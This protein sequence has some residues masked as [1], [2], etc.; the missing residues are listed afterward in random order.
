MVKKTFK[1]GNRIKGN[2]SIKKLRKNK[3]KTKGGSGPGFVN[4]SKKSNNSKKSNKDIGDMDFRYVH[5]D[6]EHDFAIRQK[7]WNEILKSGIKDNRAANILLNKRIEELEE[8]E[9]INQMMSDD[10]EYTKEQK[11][12]DKDMKNKQESG[13]IPI[14]PRSKQPTYPLPLR[15]VQ[16]PTYPL[17]LRSVQ[18]PR[19]NYYNIP[20]PEKFDNIF[21]PTSKPISQDISS[22][23][24][25]ESDN[26]QEFNF[27]LVFGTNNSPTQN[28][29][30][31][32]RKKRNTRNT[33][34][35]KKSDEKKSNDIKP[36]AP[37]EKSKMESLIEE[38]ESRNR[39]IFNF[40][41][42]QSKN[43]GPKINLKE[44]QGSLFEEKQKSKP[45]SNKSKQ[46]SNKPKSKKS[47]SN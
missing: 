45:K 26:S 37:K 24:S 34:K 17:P 9:K 25:Q 23:D 4:P 22:P 8:K 28:P 33:R 1:A 35:N 32:E 2:R 19:T 36:G 15:S 41:L 18:Q 39:S 29:P 44:L 16:Q 43:E 11:K 30:S 46:K 21:E 12:I 13:L 42:I 20:L 14:P 40:P 3:Q 10:E 27:D 38:N 47:K 5:H 31:V 7:I 6:V